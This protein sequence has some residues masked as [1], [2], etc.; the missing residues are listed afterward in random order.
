[1]DVE[2]VVSGDQKWH[3]RCARPVRL[4]WPMALFYQDMSCFHV[5]L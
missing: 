4:D 1:M 3:L 5:Q 2:L